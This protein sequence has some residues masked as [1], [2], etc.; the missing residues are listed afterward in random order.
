VGAWCVDSDVRR[1]AP[2]THSRLSMSPSFYLCVGDIIIIIIITTTT[3]TTIII[4]IMKSS[5]DRNNNN[6]A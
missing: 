4:I 1:P 3:T 5:I 6:N 2:A